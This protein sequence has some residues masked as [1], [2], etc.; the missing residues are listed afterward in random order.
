[1]RVHR[2]PIQEPTLSSPF[3]AI[4]MY[5]PAI[6]LELA[7]RV[8]GR[9]HDTALANGWR[10]VFAVVDSTDH[11]VALHRMDG[12]HHASIRVAQG[13]ASTAVNFKRPSKVFEDAIAAGGAGV[14]LLALE[15][16]VPFEGGIPLLQD[17]CIVGAIGV[18]GVQSMEDGVAAQ[19]GASVTNG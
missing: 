10:M 7:L 16:M 14:R 5:G 3:P 17:G 4:P 2:R 12:V 9:A 6:S 1:M 19:A 18:S 8:I 13:K 15:G 11:L